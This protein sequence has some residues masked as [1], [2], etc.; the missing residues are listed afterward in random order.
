LLMPVDP[1]PALAA[2]VLFRLTTYWPGI[3]LGYLA[4]ISLESE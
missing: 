2:A 1:G 4:L 3:P